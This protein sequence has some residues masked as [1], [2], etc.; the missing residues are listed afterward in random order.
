MAVPLSS[1]GTQAQIGWLHSSNSNV[2]LAGV[3][4]WVL[5]RGKD[6][7]VTPTT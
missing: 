3:L 4:R 6:S 2:E 5:P 1:Q 7:I